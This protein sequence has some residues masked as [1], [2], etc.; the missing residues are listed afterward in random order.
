[1]FKKNSKLNTIQ[2]KYCSCLVKV[3]SKKTS[4]YGI[5]TSSVYGSRKL[6]RKINVKCSKTYKLPN[7][8]KKQLFNLA[9]EKKVS[10]SKKMN[11]SIIMSLLRKKIYKELN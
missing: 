1:M 10:V 6:K 8:T 9:K 7:L 4:P 5:C 3:R 11:R 2:R